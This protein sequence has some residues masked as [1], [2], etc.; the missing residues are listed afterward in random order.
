MIKQAEQEALAGEASEYSMLLRRLKVFRF[1]VKL[2]IEKGC[3]VPAC[4]V[5]FA[6]MVAEYAAM[7]QQMQHS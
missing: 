5:C 3:T 4:P 6:R 7:G 2:P 1:S